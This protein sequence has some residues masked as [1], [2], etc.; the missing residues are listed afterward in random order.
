[1]KFIRTLTHAIIGTRCHRFCMCCVFSLIAV[2]FNS[3]L[4]LYTFFAL[5]YFPVFHTSF[6]VHARATRLL[7][8]ACACESVCACC[9][10]IGDS[11]QRQRRWRLWWHCLHAEF[12]IA[13]MFA[14]CVVL[15]VQRCER[16]FPLVLVC[17][18]YMCQNAKSRSRN[19]CAP[20]CLTVRWET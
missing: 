1:M 2:N 7:A 6:S 15:F 16:L 13:N 12:V 3:I 9:S 17:L 20:T 10:C 18:T 8:N 11:R 5:N 14:V 19:F 4:C